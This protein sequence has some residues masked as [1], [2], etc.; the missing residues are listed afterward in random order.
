MTKY[1]PTPAPHPRRDDPRGGGARPPAP[2]PGRPRTAG[3][4]VARAAV[5]VP[6]H[7]SLRGAARLLARQRATAAAVTDAEG[8]CV[9]VLPPAAFV[10]LAAREEARFGARAVPAAGVCSDWQVVEPAQAPADEACRHM[11]PDPPLVPPETPVAELAALV[12][13]AGT[14]H[15]VVIDRQGR[16]LGLVSAYDVLRA[17]AAPGGGAEGPDRPPARRAFAATAGS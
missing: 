3:D 10:G 2:G 15:A 1:Q 17:V 6:Q 8:R 11:H 13:K 4:L 16:P 7:M 14:P 9:G 5:T 12:L